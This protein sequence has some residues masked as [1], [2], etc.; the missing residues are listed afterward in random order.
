M[1]DGAVR[2]ALLALRVQDCGWVAMGSTPEQLVARGLLPF[3]KDFPVFCIPLPQKN[4]QWPALSVKLR[5]TTAALPSIPY[6]GW[7]C[8]KA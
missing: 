7:R 3:G 8:S 2:Y 1:V 4:T 5:T 6:L